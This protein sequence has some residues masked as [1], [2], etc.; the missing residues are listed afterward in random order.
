MMKHLPYTFF[1]YGFS[2]HDNTKVAEELI[3]ITMKLGHA[4]L[5]LARAKPFMKRHAH[6]SWI[7]VV[8]TIYMLYI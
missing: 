8:L 4:W 7:A 5:E 1:M 2:L 3:I 6:A